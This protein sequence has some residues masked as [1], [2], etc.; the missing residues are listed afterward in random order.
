MRHRIDSN[1]PPIVRHGFRF[2]MW[3]AKL[4]PY[5]LNSEDEK[6]SKGRA[7]LVSGAGRK[8]PHDLEQ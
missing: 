1:L 5:R 3:V 2:E 7:T 8:T 6:A 4:K